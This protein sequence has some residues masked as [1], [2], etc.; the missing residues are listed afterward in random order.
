MRGRNAAA[1]VDIFILIPKSRYIVQ[2][3]QWEI[4]EMVGERFGFVI[5]REM[6][7][8]INF[9]LIEKHVCFV[10]NFS[11]QITGFNSHLIA[12]DNV[13]EAK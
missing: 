12:L 2:L 7:P 8:P 1:D 9:F 6:S 13:P 3:T 10:S 5:Y 4:W 11:H